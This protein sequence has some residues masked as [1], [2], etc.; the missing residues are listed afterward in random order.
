MESAK[1]IFKN[2]VRENKQNPQILTII[3]DISFDLGRKK[4][5]D[6]SENEI[7]DTI[8]ELFGLFTIALKEETLRERVSQALWTD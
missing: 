7:K 5:K 8:K 2:T 3:R 1:I 6:L 4:I